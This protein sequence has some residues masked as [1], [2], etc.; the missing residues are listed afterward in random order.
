MDDQNQNQGQ[1]APVGD[2][3]AQPAGGWTPPPAEPPVQEPAPTEPP[4]PEPAPAPETPAE[5]V[6]N[7]DQGGQTPPAPGTDNPNQVG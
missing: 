2:Q 4:A 5:P 1:Q 7:P 3:P 6:D